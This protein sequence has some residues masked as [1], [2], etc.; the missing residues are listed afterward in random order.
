M[1]EKKKLIIKM[2]LMW[3]VF[4]VILI[5]AIMFPIY[6]DFG[7]YQFKVMNI[8]FIAAFITFTR[9]IFL[10]QYTFWSHWQYVKISLVFLVIPLLAYMVNG[11]GGFQKFLDEVD[12]NVWMA[13]VTEVNHENLLTYIRNEMTFFGVGAI[14]S[15]GI[16]P[17]RMIVSVWRQRNRGKV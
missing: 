2:E 11:L 17:I 5:A 8:V 3:I 1:E 7:G 9:S 6:K 10:L 15:A 12:T 4:T 13:E 16:L 14:V